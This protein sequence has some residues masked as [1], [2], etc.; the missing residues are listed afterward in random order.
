MEHL[1]SNF[2]NQ[3]DAK[4]ILNIIITNDCCYSFL[5]NHLPKKMVIIFFVDIVLYDKYVE[6]AIKM[7]KWS[8][9]IR[10]ESTKFSV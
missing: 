2:N 8:N 1:I 3:V 5:L 10:S 4:Q 6:I 9:S 7:T